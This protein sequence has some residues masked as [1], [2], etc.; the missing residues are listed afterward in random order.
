MAFSRTFKGCCEA[1]Q[2]CANNQYIYASLLIGAHQHWWVNANGTHRQRR[3]SRDKDTN[4]YESQWE[5]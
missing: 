1:G 5:Q 4:R 2:P 3:V